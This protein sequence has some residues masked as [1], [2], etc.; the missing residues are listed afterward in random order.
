MVNRQ[1]RG[2]TRSFDLKICNRKSENCNCLS[3][4][5]P[6]T[7]IQPLKFEKVMSTGVEQFCRTG[8]RCYKASS[9]LKI[10]SDKRAL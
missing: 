2:K 9:K 10:I 4:P 7:C 8:S 3:R 5:K 1:L 6:V